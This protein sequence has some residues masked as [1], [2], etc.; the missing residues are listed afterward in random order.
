MEGGLELAG[1][2]RS[3]SPGHSAKY[4]GYNILELRIN[5]VLDMQLVQS[6]EV[7]SSNACELEGIKRSMQF[8]LQATLITDRHRSV[9]H[10]IREDLIHNNPGALF[11]SLITIQQARKS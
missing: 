5:K 7:G 11:P 2:G 8:L 1:D 6:N 9:G 4:G 3:D 10:Y